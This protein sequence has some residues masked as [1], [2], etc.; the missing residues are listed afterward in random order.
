MDF[1]RP[2]RAKE[3]WGLREEDWGRFAPPARRAH[4]P[5]LTWLS[6]IRLRPRRA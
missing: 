3:C 6:L 5:A 1:L 2:G 4:S